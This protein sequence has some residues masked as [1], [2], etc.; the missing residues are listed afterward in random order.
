MRCSGISF[1][2]VA[3]VCYGLR[4]LCPG[5]TVYT[6]GGVTG[7]ARSNRSSGRHVFLFT[8]S[9]GRGLAVTLLRR[10]LGGI[11]IGVG[12]V[13]CHPTCSRNVRAGGVLGLLLSVVPGH[14]GALDCTRNGLV[15]NAYDDVCG[16]KEDTNRRLNL[17]VDFSCSGLLATHA[18]AFTRRSGMGGGGGGSSPM[19]RLR[20]SRGQVCFSSGGGGKAGRCCG[21]PSIFEGSGGGR[22]PFLKFDSVRRFRR[23]R[24]C[25]VQDILRS[26]LAACSGCI[27]IGPVRCGGPALL[28]T[29]ST[30]FGGRSRL[31]H[32]VL[33][34]S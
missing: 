32:S 2:G 19:C 4:N 31:L 21:R 7:G 16:G 5:D 27:F 22:V 18:L 29:R 26:F 6:F 12:R 13:A 1:S 10:Y 14:G 11:G 33:S 9:G 30:R 3:D 23:S 25:L 34:D 8:S 20:F 15:Y 28:G 24:T 17:R